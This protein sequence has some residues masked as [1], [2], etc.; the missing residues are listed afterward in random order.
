MTKKMLY[1]V[2][3]TNSQRNSS[4]V[5]NITLEL[6]ASL[7]ERDES[8]Q[9]YLTKCKSTYEQLHGTITTAESGYTCDELTAESTSLAD[10]IVLL[11]QFRSELN[12]KRIEKNA[13]SLVN[14]I[15][16]THVGLQK[17]LP[18]SCKINNSVVVESI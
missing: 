11:Q 18:N 14:K 12:D 13:P 16:T 10:R 1:R 5:Y 17:D 8:E 3:K 6:L 2:G 9:L 4:T 15:T 7:L